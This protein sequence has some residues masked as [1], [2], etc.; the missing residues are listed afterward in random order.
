MLIAIPCTARY[1]FKSWRPE[2]GLGVRPIRRL[3]PPFPLCAEGGRPAPQLSPTA[4]TWRGGVPPRLCGADLGR[5]GPAHFVPPPARFV[6][7]LDAALDGR[8][9]CCRFSSRWFTCICPLGVGWLDG[10]G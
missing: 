8:D 6:V 5:A 2:A 3:T 7:M 10:E 9:R 4:R 1:G